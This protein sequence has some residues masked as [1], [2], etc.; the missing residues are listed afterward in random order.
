V[1]LVFPIEDEDLQRRTEAI[2]ETMCSDTLNTRVLLPNG[3]YKMIDRRGKSSVN[4]QLA[5][6]KEAKERAD[7][8]KHLDWSEGFKPQQRP[9]DPEI[10][11][12]S[13]SVSI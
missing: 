8:Q 3:E 7:R 9:D 2:L 12:E 5:F 6:A 1:E 10:R 11:N 4:C 13:E